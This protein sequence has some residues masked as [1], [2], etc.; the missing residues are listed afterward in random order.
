MF[1]GSFFT[2]NTQSAELWAIICGDWMLKVQGVHT[3]DML[4]I[5]RGRIDCSF[6]VMRCPWEAISET[7]CSRERMDWSLDELERKV[8]PCW[9]LFSSKWLPY[10]TTRWS[11][12]T[13]AG[14]LERVLSQ[15]D[16]SIQCTWQQLVSL[17]SG[18]GCAVVAHLLPVHDIDVAQSAFDW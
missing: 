13:S 11:Q 10:A 8:C 2:E 14:I 18:T 16:C 4:S 6:K 3:V 17:R 1:E 9:V 15:R 5:Y 7:M 12:W